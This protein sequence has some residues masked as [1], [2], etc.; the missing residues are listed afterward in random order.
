MSTSSTDSTYPS[1]CFP[2][3]RISHNAVHILSRPLQLKHSML[4]SS[5]AVCV[6]CCKRHDMSTAAKQAP[7]TCEAGDAVL[8]RRIC[9]DW[10][11]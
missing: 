1:I 3:L 10:G 9:F 4:G 6:A 7:R 2:L 8:R 11:A 5:V